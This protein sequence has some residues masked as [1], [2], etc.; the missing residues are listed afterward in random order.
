MLAQRF[1]E[2]FL[3]RKQCSNRY[4]LVG[5]SLCE[6]D[7]NPSRPSLHSIVSAYR[8]K[9]RRGVEWSVSDSESFAKCPPLKRHRPLI[10][11]VTASAVTSF[12]EVG[13]KKKKLHQKPGDS[14]LILSGREKIIKTSADFSH[15]IY[16]LQN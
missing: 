2:G 4:C 5:H 14:R 8:K 12:A 6:T 11:A 1:P 13:K 10:S 7:R 15:F 9:G 16:R 3:N